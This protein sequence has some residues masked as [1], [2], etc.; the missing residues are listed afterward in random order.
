MANIYLGLNGTEVLL[1]PIR[2]RDGAV[3]GAPID[4]GKQIDESRML[5]GS[6]RRNIRAVHPRS[7]SF[8]W[9]FLSDTEMATFWTLR[10]YNRRLRFQ[11]N[12]EDATWRWVVITDFRPEPIINLAGCETGYWKLA[13]ALGESR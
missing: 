13:L 5:D 3:P 12:W 1:P 6:I 4:A 9:D 10:N 7:W 8:N 2:W 11:N